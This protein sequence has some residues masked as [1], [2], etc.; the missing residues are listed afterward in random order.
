MPSVVAPFTVITPVDVKVVV[1]LS[2]RFQ[3]PVESTPPV[4]M[5]PETVVVLV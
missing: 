4:V 1:L 2:A 3:M 5:L